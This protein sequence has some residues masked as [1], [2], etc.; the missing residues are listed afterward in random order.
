MKLSVEGKLRLAVHLAFLSGVG[1][2]TNALAEDAQPN[3]SIAP[4][5][6]A[7]QLGGVKITG[8]RI[9]QPDLTGTSSLTIIS[10]EELKLQGT[11]NVET[12]INNLPQSFA[13]YST[14]DSNG[15]SGTA[16]VN[17]RGLGAQE[18]LVLIDGKRLMPG[19]A[20]Q[21]PPS[22]DVNFI[23]AAL[24][25]SV[26]VLSGGAS[27]VYGSDAVAG[28]VNFKLKQDFQ[29]FMVDTEATRTDHSD[30]STYDATLVW[31]NNFAGGKGNVTVYAGYTK[32]EGLTQDRRHFSRNSL[33]TPASGDVHL[34]QGSPVSPTGYIIS[35]DRYNNLPAGSVYSAAV[36]PAGT[37]S[38]VDQSQNPSF[39]FAPYNYL[40][41]PDRRYHLGGFAHDQLNEHLEIY[42]SAMF[43]D[44]RTTAAVA[45]SGFFGE[46]H[47]HVPCNSPLLSAQEVD[48]LCTQAGLAPDAI[49]DLLPVRRTP[50][51]G[52]RLDD[53]RHS[54]YRILIGARGDLWDGWSYDASAQRGEVI[55]QDGELNYTDLAKVQ[56]A[57]TTTI[58]AMG[59]AVCASGN[60]GCVPLDV[61]QAGKLT[62]AQAD[63]IRGDAFTQSNLVEQVVTGTVTGELGRYGVKSPL[64]TDGVGVAGGWEYRTEALDFRP[65][66]LTATDDALGGFGAARKPQKGAYQVNEAFGEV[67]LP[68]L[69]NQR[70]AKLLQVDA[71]YRWGNYTIANDAHS[72]KG[73]IKFAP[74]DD[75]TLRGSF[76]RATRAPSITEL[77]TPAATGLVAFSDPCSGP[78]PKLS[79]AECEN[80]GLAAARYGS[81]RDC[82]AG[83]CNALTS[84][85]LALV[86]EKS[87]T[88]SLG[89]V[90]TPS[91]SKGLT[92]TIDYFDISI[93]QQINTDLPAVIFNQCAQGDPASCAAIHRSSIG[94]LDGGADNFIAT[95]NTNIGGFRTRGVDFHSDYR[96]RL[97][98]VGLANGGTLLFAY[99]ATWLTEFKT[100]P[101]PG[102][103]QFDCAGLFGATCSAGSANP[104]GVNPRYRHTFRT[105]WVA[106]I[107]LTLSANWRW[108]GGSKLDTNQPDQTLNNGSYDFIDRAIHYKS[109]IDLSGSYTLPTKERNI[110]LRAGISN[111]TGQGPPTVSTNDPHPISSPPFGNANTFPGV[112]DSLGR[113][114]FVGLNANF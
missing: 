77:F 100:D 81:L 43:M 111:I 29:G 106:P 31:G 91:F 56:D 34:N 88:R 112:Y 49:T 68:I 39:N 59:N 83:Q 10:D 33:A 28:V 98:D 109:Y 51:L 26:E 102:V 54:D 14:S 63:Y 85:N 110:T 94:T 45:P 99:A 47:A 19:D 97:R 8:S 44:N 76:Q 53:L 12:L 30:A 71:A 9:A 42:G 82:K 23:P 48:F 32:L 72:W 3:P 86:P 107:G 65:D 89:I 4:A 52:P 90:L 22:A 78:T 25:D 11:V 36:D 93:T 87:I 67:Q 21:S 58:D 40:Q 104:T 35:Y 46:R 64:A 62:Q 95:P 75:V 73:G 7:V 41:R 18:T 1:A 27:A 105:T 13:G 79:L 69:E 92:A 60:K 101:G 17:L 74:T 80:T 6:K 114:M 38:L 108:I 55:Q 2:A 24:V 16:T 66:T 50:E 20:L 96:L 113:V 61:F 37:R 70:F 15:A 5:N 84:G 57:F 103:H